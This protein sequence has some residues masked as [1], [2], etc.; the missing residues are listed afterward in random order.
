MWP[1]LNLGPLAIPTAA[2]VYILGIWA[3]LSTVERAAVRVKQ[4]PVAVYAVAVTALVAGV[5]GARL[6]FVA[7]NWRAY[8]SQPLGIIW[9][10]TSGYQF[11][12]G[13]LI[14]IAGAV[15]A[16]RAR[17]LPLAPTLDALAPGLLLALTTVSL[18]DFLA[19][20]GY[21]VAADLPWSISYFGVLRHPVQLYEI[22][23]ALLALL[24]WW[25]TAGRVHRPGQPFLVASALYSAGLLLVDAYRANTPLTEGG[26]HI[27]QIV[28]L[29][30]LVGSLF[31]L[32]RLAEANGEREGE[33]AEI[34]VVKGDS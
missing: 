12:A 13:L 21:G 9:P 5:V 29:V 2:F 14:G 7:L 15:F 27:V 19:G 8:A 20:P 18:A 24:A 4:S 28:A 17:R 6:V 33:E 26:Y 16:A 10:L 34:V 30:T 25:R 11:E 3:A 31:F 23:V 32:S 1:A 22:V